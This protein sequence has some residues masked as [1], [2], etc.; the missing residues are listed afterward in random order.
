MIAATI[1]R[2]ALAGA[3]LVG[4]SVGPAAAAT[5]TGTDEVPAS[6]VGTTLPTVREASG[7]FD[8]LVDFSTLSLEP[9]AGGCRL[10]VSGTLRFTGTLEGSAYGTTRALVFAPCEQVATAPPGTYADV[11][12]FEGTFEGTVAGTPATGPLGYAG[13]TSPGGAIDAAIWLGGDVPAAARA[14][15]TVAVGGTYTGVTLT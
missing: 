7:Q 12:R 3:L 8:A 5:G 15:A 11:F 1:R 13:V 2:A 9:V 6:L 10:T 4:A 14:T